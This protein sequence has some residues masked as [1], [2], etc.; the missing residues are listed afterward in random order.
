MGPGKRFPSPEIHDST[1][2]GAAKPDQRRCTV[3][4]CH[5]ATKNH[6]PTTPSPLGPSMRTKPGSGRVSPPTWEGSWPSERHFPPRTPRHPTKPTRGPRTTTPGATPA[7]S[8]DPTTRLTRL[9]GLR[10][11]AISSLVGVGWVKSRRSR[12]DAEGALD[13]PHPDQHTH[14]AETAQPHP[15]LHRT[16]R[17]HRATTRTTRHGITPARPCNLRLTAHHAH[18]RFRN[19]PWVRPCGWL[20][21]RLILAASSGTRPTRTV[22]VPALTPGD[23]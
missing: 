3:R 6:R 14:A 23:R 12:R 1:S 11:A 20:C 19:P 8:P 5:I 18:R 4:I 15:A 21:T 2:L 10:I 16:T 7:P 17:A 9:S 13:A 22:R